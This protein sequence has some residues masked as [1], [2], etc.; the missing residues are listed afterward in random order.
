MI[1]IRC[2]G[3]NAGREFGGGCERDRAGDDRSGAGRGSAGEPAGSWKRRGSAGGPAGSWKR[4]GSAGEPAGSWK[5]HSPS[6]GQDA[7]HRAA[8]AVEAARV[9]GRHDPRRAEPGAGHRADRGLPDGRHPAVQP[10]GHPDRVGPLPARAG[11]AGTRRG[12]A[13]HPAPDPRAPPALA[14]R[15]VPGDR[16]RHR[17]G[18]DRRRG[19]RGDRAVPHH[20]PRG[21]PAGRPARRGPGRLRRGHPGRPAAA[22]G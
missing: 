8:R 5:R 21:L 1:G 9:P 7:G 17:A 18:R 15:G 13:A 3:G 6:G 10:A 4:R 14:G 20:D 2:T 22:A 11:R 12:G 16:V 19:G